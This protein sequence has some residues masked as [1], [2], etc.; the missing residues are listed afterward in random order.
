MN[1]TRF[2]QKLLAKQR[3]LDDEITRLKTDTQSTDTVEV[4][5]ATDSAEADQEIGDAMQKATALTRTLEQVRDALLR[6]EDGTYGRCAVCGNEIESA[7]LE[8]IPW[9]QYCL[10][11]QEKQEAR[12][13]M[14]Q[15][16]TL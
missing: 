9:A 13:S 2:M 4:R 6:I 15:G 11:D 10:K 14:A 12:R 3:E 5:D 1:T 16:S 8:A 7:R